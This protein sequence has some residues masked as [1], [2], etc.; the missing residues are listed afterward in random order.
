M[1]IWLLM[2][3]T[4]C[5]NKNWYID[6]SCD[7]GTIVSEMKTVVSGNTFVHLI[8]D[9]FN[10]NVEFI[11][12]TISSKMWKLMLDWRRIICVCDVIYCIYLGANHFGSLISIMYS[13][14]ISKIVFCPGTQPKGR[15]SRTDTMFYLHK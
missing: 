7:N 14:I 11:A 10:F 4:D 15:Y 5:Y 1:F 2:S 8:T 13:C 6:E 12:Y 9:N 3:L